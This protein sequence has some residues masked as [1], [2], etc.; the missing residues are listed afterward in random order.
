MSWFGQAL[1]NS[2]Q[3]RFSKIWKVLSFFAFTPP[4]FTL[5]RILSALAYFSPVFSL[6]PYLPEFIFPFVKIFSDIIYS[7]EL[8]VTF[9]ENWGYEWFEFHPNPPI[10]VLNMTENFLGVFDPTLLEHFRIH[11]ISNQVF[12]W[13]LLRTLFTE[14]LPTNDWLKLFDHTF[15]MPPIFLYYLVVSYLIHFRT[16]LMLLKKLED[17][18]VWICSCCNAEYWLFLC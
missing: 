14:V 17:F 11:N 18:K 13:P 12:V 4:I 2:G 9:F 3:H 1:S 8:T 15:S 5:F 16:R 6:C 7:F 10:T